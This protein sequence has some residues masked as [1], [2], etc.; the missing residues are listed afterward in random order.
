[1]VR[2]STSSYQSFNLDWG[3]SLG[4]G[5]ITSDYTPY[6]DSL[7]LRL[8]LRWLNLA[9]ENNSLAHY[10]KGTLSPWYYYRRAPT[11][12]KRKVSG[13]ISLLLSRFF[14]PFPHGTGSLSVSREYL[15]LDNGLPRFR[16]GFSCPVLLRNS[17]RV[18]NLFEYRTLTFYGPCFHRILLKL[19]L[20]LLMLLQP[21]GS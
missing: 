10:A 5:S 7:S 19:L 1:M 18:H 16:Q 11:A 4:F 8:H 14:S 2:S 20:P 9:T 15:A 12:S 17:S 21:Q 13:S 3:R 6:S